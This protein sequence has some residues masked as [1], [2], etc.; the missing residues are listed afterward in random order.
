MLGWLK[1][2]NKALYDQF[3]AEHTKYKEDLKAPKETTQAQVDPPS[4]TLTKA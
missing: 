3:T 4:P 2:N 1:N